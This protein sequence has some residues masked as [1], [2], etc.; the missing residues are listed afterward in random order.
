MSSDETFLF[1]H[2]PKTAGT[3]LRQ[4]VEQAYARQEW[5]A[6]YSGAPEGRLTPSEFRALPDA[7]KRPLPKDAP[8][9]GSFRKAEAEAGAAEAANPAGQ[10]QGSQAS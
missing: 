4:V 7:V 9:P 6:I 3:A 1:M 5:K 8:K 2:I 10:G